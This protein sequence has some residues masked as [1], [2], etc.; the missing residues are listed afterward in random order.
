MIKSFEQILASI[1]RL[2]MSSGCYVVKMTRIFVLLHSLFFG[3]AAFAAPNNSPMI[4]NSRDINFGAG[5]DK[6]T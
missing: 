3:T 4:L 5:L 6:V 2:S 1:R